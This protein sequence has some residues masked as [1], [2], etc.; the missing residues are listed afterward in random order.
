MRLDFQETG[1]P[2]AWISRSLDFQELGFLG[3]WISKAFMVFVHAT[4]QSM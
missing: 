4:V 3:A 2:G 1:L